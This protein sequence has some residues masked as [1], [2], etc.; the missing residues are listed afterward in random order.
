VI[1]WQQGS[2][3][4]AA[5]EFQEAIRAKPD[6]ERAHYIL[7]SVLRQKGDLDGAL[8]ELRRALQLDPNDAGAHQALGM[9]L[10][11][12]GDTHGAAE[13]FLRA[14][15][16]NKATMNTQA[17]TL[18]THTGARQLRQGDVEG[19]IQQ[20]RS[21]LKL[22]PDFAPAHYQLALALKQKGEL[23]Q[24][25]AEFEKAHQLDPHLKSPRE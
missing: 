21:A 5:K 2:L 4:E 10:K 3:D 19:S 7:G 22:A 1:L 20:F 15:T 16:L 11:Q 24:A 13:E 8:K 9:A 6:Y 14:E 12:Q 17:A 23:A 18:A 25:Q